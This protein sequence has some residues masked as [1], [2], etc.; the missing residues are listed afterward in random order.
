MTRLEIILSLILTLSAL[1][2]VGVFLYARG[3]ILR[4]VSIAEELGDLRT[5]I[6]SFSA[7]LRSVYELETFYG[8]QTLQALLE[9]ATSFDEQMETFEYIYG[10]IEEEEQE[11][12]AE[13]E[14]NQE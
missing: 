6:G 12:D 3:A 10:L 7:H 8:D 14:E 2:N 13:E 11:P 9:H 4:L 1:F 5:M